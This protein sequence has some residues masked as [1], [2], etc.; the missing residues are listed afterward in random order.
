MVAIAAFAL[1]A[2]TTSI[3]AIEPKPLSR[4]QAAQLLASMGYEDVAV[5]AIVQGGFPPMSGSPNGAT[6]LAIGRSNGRVEKLEKQFLYD[7]EIGWFYYEYNRNGLNGVLK[8][9]IW[10]SSGYKQLRPIM[11]L[12]D[13]SAAEMIL[14]TWAS[15]DSDDMLTYTN[16]GQWKQTGSAGS[17]TGSW[18]IERGV[19]I[20]TESGPSGTTRQFEVLGLDKSALVLKLKLKNGADAELTWHRIRDE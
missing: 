6:V 17:R 19:M 4:S 16:N 7:V 10:T 1:T 18:E 14:G 15:D 9:R 8:L 13:S 11:S 20:S 3:L 12:T 5:G 2:S